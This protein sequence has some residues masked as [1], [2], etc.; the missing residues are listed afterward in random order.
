MSYP[1]FFSPHKNLLLPLL[2]LISTSSIWAQSY[3]LINEYP[4]D[5]PFAVADQLISS[6]EILLMWDYGTTS[7]PLEINHQIFD[8]L[9]QG[10]ALQPKPRYTETN[11]LNYGLRHIA[12]ATGDLDNDHYDEFVSVYHGPNRQLEV[13]VSDVD[14]FN[15]N[16]NQGNRSV[17]DARIKDTPT[18]SLGYEGQVKLAIGNFDSDADG[19]FVVVYRNADTDDLY[20]RLF[21]QNNFVPS[22]IAEIHDEKMEPVNNRVETFE[23]IATDLDMDGKDEIVLAAFEKKNGQLEVFVKVY[24]LTPSGLMARARKVV[25]R[26]ESETTP[27]L[28]GLTHGDFDHDTVDEL[29]IGINKQG[30]S[31]SGQSY[32]DTFLYLLR[33]ADDL[34][35]AERSFLELLVVDSSRVGTAEISNQ[36]Q[37]NM[38]LNPLDLEAGDLN[39]DGRDELVMG[40]YGAVRVF[41]VDDSLSFQFE[42]AKYTYQPENAYHVNSSL[43]IADLDGDISEEI[44]FVQDRYMQTNDDDSLSLTVYVLDINNNLDQLNELTRMENFDQVDLKNG[45]RR[46]YTLAVGD[47]DG[48]GLRLGQGRRFSMTDIKQ[49]LVILNAPPT[50]YDVLGGT[51]YDINDCFSG[52][53]NYSATYALQTATTIS[54]S[55]QLNRAWGVSATASGNASFGIVDVGAS[56]S[57]SY[58]ENFSESNA[59]SETI[60]ISIEATTNHDDM[61]YATL[62]N[63]TVWE[64]PLY[65]GDELVGHLVSV[66][67]ELSSQEWFPSK[68]YKATRFI[69]DHEVDN[70]LSYREYPNDFFLE[71]PSVGRAINNF[72]TYTIDQGLSYS[73]SVSFNDFDESANEEENTIGLAVGANAGIGGDSW[74]LG[75]ETEGTY[76]E[77]EIETQSVSIDSTIQINVSFDG[78]DRS[79]GENQYGISP[80]L[81]WSRTGALVLDYAVRPELPTGGSGNNWWSQNYAQEHDPAFILPWLHDPEKGLTLSD[82]A[83]RYETKSLNIYPQ[84]PQPGDKVRVTAYIHNWSLLPTNDYIEVSFYFGHPNQ[85]GTLITDINGQSLHITPDFVDA[86]GR[87]KVVMEFTMPSGLGNFPRLYAHIDPMG[88]L[89]EIHE[90]NNIGYVTVESFSSVSIEEEMEE[91]VAYGKLSMSYPNP[92][93]EETAIRFRVPQAEKVQ[94]TLYD[95]QGKMI[96][97]LLNEHKQSGEFEVLVSGQNLPDGLYFYQLQIGDHRESGKLIKR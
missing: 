82:T 42:V 85:G 1:S 77:S 69:P 84:N 33:N 46:M 11:R 81:Y 86:R 62:L 55:S 52:G 54:A 56:V 97:A 70:I 25:N 66:V 4:S 90:R 19:E 87:E 53:C 79:I 17:I 13:Y 43:E 34:G 35:S 32:D 29:V 16:I 20:I 10:T 18:G 91:Q 49:P 28:L 50:H 88:K 59:Q 27:I 41:S 6:S 3:E 93:S 12:L 8:Y 76:D 2:M 37:T 5:N 64:Y 63:Y 15:F 45:R 61:I 83:R 21:D 47:F 51:T 92:F 39:G 44:V 94:M 75:V 68:S 58:G 40:N 36:L 89:T 60:E 95:M 48:D 38:L 14:T 74:G 7:T 31:N 24:E 72:Q 71:N 80:F 23:V 73:W 9:G 57:A 67:P 26:Q 78:I 96:K 22:E 30:A 65:E